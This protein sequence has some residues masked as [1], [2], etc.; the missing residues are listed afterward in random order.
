MNIIPSSIKALFSSIPW[1]LPSETKHSKVKTVSWD[2]QL[3]MRIKKMRWFLA[4]IIL[5]AG[6][7][8]LAQEEF[9]RRIVS[10]GPSITK[11]LYLLAVGDKIV[12]VTTYCQTPQ[13]EDPKGKVGSVTE[14]NVEKILSLKP[15]LVLATSLANRERV[16]KLEKLGIKVVRFSYARNFSEICEQFLEKGRLIGVEKRAKDIV[17]DAT[18]RVESTKNKV[19]GLPKP[20]VFIQLG[21]KPLFTANKKSFLNDYVKLAGGINIAEDAKTGLY[22]REKV[23]RRDPDHIIIASMGIAGEDE[24]KIWRE[25]QLRLQICGMYR[26]TLKRKS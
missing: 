6:S 24:K 7:I 21:T 16:E 11:E 23:I 14:I 1:T 13:G 18:V 22:S 10:L 3:K 5:H 9:P 25:L 12:G 26:L 19:K 17:R 20:K 8:C 2:S 4:L 15:D